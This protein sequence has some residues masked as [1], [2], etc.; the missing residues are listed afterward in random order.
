MTERSSHDQAWK[1]AHAQV[2]T[3]P[4]AV[5][6]RA[7]NGPMGGGRVLEFAVVLDIPEL[8]LTEEQI[9]ANAVALANGQRDV[10]PDRQIFSIRCEFLDSAFQ[11][12]HAKEQP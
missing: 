8:R 10:W 3:V 1:R 7:A 5:I 2:I 12:E 4:R 11:P 6:N 9:M